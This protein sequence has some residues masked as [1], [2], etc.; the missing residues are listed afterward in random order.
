MSEQEQRE[1]ELATGAGAFGRWLLQERELRGLDRDEVAR[2]TRLPPGMIEAL[3]SGVPER[4]P[5]KAYVFGYLRT[6]AG[7]VGLDADDVVLRWQE[8]V[9]PEETGAVAPRRRRPRAILS[10][11]AV[12]IGIAVVVA[13]AVA[14]FAPPRQRAPLLLRKVPSSQRAPYPSEPPP[15]TR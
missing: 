11:I 14:L 10:L 1:G 8:V 6:Y 7:V 4:M 13:L 9:G 5:P 3:E 2:L 12:L 15:A